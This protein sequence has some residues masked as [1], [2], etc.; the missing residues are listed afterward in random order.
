MRKITSLVLILLAVNVITSPTVNAA[1]SIRPGASCPIQDENRSYKG[2]I[3]TCVKVGKKWVWDKG[4]SSPTTSKVSPSASLPSPTPAPTKVN[5]LAGL[6]WVQK[7][8][9]LMN[10]SLIMKS[11]QSNFAFI[12]DGLNFQTAYPDKFTALDIWEDKIIA[13]PSTCITDLYVSGIKSTDLKQISL[14]K[15]QHPDIYSYSILKGANF[16]SNSRYIF[17]LTSF[18][19]IDGLQSVIYRI[20]TQTGARTPIYATYC[21]STT[22]KSCAYGYRVSGMKADHH[23]NRL[24]I[25]VSAIGETSVGYTSSF[26]LTINQDSGGIVLKSYKSM[27]TDKRIFYDY[28]QDANLNWQFV[29][30]VKEGNAVERLSEIQFMNTGEMVYVRSSGEIGRNLNRICKL[31]GPNL[32]SCSSIAPFNYVSDLI[33]LGDNL[34]LYSTLNFNT[35]QFGAGIFDFSSKGVTPV[36]NFV[37]STWLSSFA[38]FG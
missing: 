23:S 32:E 2:K 17:A 5:E 7:P 8:N 21:Y 33:P 13:C 34:V 20:D 10:L 16:G 4:V 29:D 9:G 12:A 18:N 36:N 14:D 30:N 19:P 15:I 25:Y 1:S 26:L 6:A 3:Y 31:S 28:S 37:S 35:D 27:P 38:V 24:A 11:I 22:T